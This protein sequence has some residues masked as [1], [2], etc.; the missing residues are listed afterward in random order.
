[1]EYSAHEGQ[2]LRKLITIYL[3][4]ALAEL[5]QDDRKS[6]LQHLV[7]AVS[8]AAPQG[9]LR[10]FLDEDQA[11][12]DLLPEVRHIAPEFVDEL[13][14]Y[15]SSVPGPPPEIEQPYEPLSARELEVLHLV[16]RGYSNRQIAEALFVTLGTVKKHLNNIFSKFQVK[17][18]TQAAARAR[19]LNLID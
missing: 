15:P 6:A 5:G 18:R 9:Y 4:M 19:E 13:L 7:G 12:L 17:N 11:I 10:A 16:A 1:M 2:R 8:I 3:L 14:A